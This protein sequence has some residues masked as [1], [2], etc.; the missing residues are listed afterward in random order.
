M[1]SYEYYRDVFK[2]QQLPLAYVD[3]DLLDANIRALEKRAGGKRIRV[4][5]KSVRCRAVLEYIFRASPVFQGIM[6]FTAEEALYL[7]DNRLDNILVAYPTVHIPHIRALAQK[8]RSGAKAWLMVDSKEHLDLIDQALEGS[9]IRMPVCVDIDM[10]VDFPGL[11]FGVWRS[12]IR[13]M[14]DLKAFAEAAAA[15]K[16]AELCALM[17]YEAQ[18]AGVGDQVDGK[19]LMNGVIRTLKKVSVPRIAKFRAEAVNYLREAGFTIQLVNGGGTGSM[20]STCSEEAVTEVTVGSG[21]YNSHLFDNYS[22]FKGEPAAGFALPVCRIPKKGTYTCLGGGYIASGSTG[23]DKE[24]QPYLPESGSLLDLEGAGEVQTPVV[25]SKTV[26]LAVGDPVFLRHS[27]AGEL[28]E[29]FNRLHF[30]R[31]GKITEN[32]PTYRGEGKCFL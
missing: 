27:K 19:A 25:F 24:P 11:H 18:I 14:P 4:A 16:S 32:V 28:C 3:L 8:V 10:S 12:S 30:V 31:D 26:D 17:G 7:L 20:E 22:N 29:R 1:P 2:G 13:S 6:A 5:S 21:F 23:R 15:S 9:G